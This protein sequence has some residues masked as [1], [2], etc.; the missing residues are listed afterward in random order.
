M[1]VEIRDIRALLYYEI[2]LRW[3]EYERD[4]FKDIGLGMPQWQRRS[5][6]NVDR[7]QGFKKC[8]YSD[9]IAMSSSSRTLQ[10]WENGRGN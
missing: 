1:A 5:P 2:L 4:I 7:T 9:N 6:A 3:W 8:R 10:R